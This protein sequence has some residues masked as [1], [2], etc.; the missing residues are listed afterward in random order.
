MQEDVIYLPCSILVK[1]SLR[2]R[3]AKSML[4]VVLQ[5]NVAVQ[6]AKKDLRMFQL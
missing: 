6:T 1:K 5:E 2:G 4:R 3:G